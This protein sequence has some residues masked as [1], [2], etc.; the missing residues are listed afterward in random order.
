MDGTAGAPICGSPVLSLAQFRT[1]CSDI[2]GLVR[3]GSHSI[4]AASWD[5]SLP[6]VSFKCCRRYGQMLLRFVEMMS[7]P[8]WGRVRCLFGTRR[9]FHID[10]GD[11]I[12]S[13]LPPQLRPRGSEPA[14]VLRSGLAEGE[15][16]VVRAVGAG[17]GEICSGG[18]AT[19]P[20]PARSRVGVS[21]GASAQTPETGEAVERQCRPVRTGLKQ[22]A[23]LK[24]VKPRENG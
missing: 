14:G 15:G 18:E 13:H 22:R 2:S 23:G 8:V 12:W 4:Y 9:R 1:D 20:Y 5:G 10:S 21:G 11:R 3:L 17:V 19:A 6:W 24:T 16:W 7:P